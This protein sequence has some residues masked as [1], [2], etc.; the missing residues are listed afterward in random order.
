MYYNIIHYIVSFAI[1]VVVQLM[2]KQTL[3]SYHWGGTSVALSVDI[4]MVEQLV[5]NQTFFRKHCG[6]T[7]GA[8]SFCIIVVVRLVRQNDARA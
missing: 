7:T 3:L 8:L 5:H 6:G 4:I 2:F 1:K